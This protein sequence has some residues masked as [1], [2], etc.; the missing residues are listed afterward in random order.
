MLC[1]T[2]VLRSVIKNKNVSKIVE[3]GSS[4]H[5][6]KIYIVITQFLEDYI[7]STNDKY[8]NYDSGVIIGRKIKS[9]F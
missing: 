1:I 8:T 5:D 2:C 9:E 3:M 7:T 6:N 4:D